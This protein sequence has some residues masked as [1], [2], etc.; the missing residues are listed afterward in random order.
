MAA[1]AAARA[2]RLLKCFVC[3]KTD[4]L[5]PCAR[6]K[7]VAHCSDAHKREHWAHGHKKECFP[8][9]GPEF[10]AAAASIVRTWRQQGS[11]IR[12][13]D[14][15]TRNASVDN[16]AF[17]SLEES[18]QHANDWT[19]DWDMN[20]SRAEEAL[21]RDDELRP[22]VWRAYVAARD[23]AAAPAQDN[24][25]PAVDGVKL[26]C[27]ADKQFGFISSSAARG[28]LCGTALVALNVSIKQ[29]QGGPVHAIAGVMN[30]LHHRASQGAHVAEG[31]V[32]Q[33]GDLRCMLVRPSA[34]DCAWLQAC[35][36]APESPAFVAASNAGQSR[37]LV[38]VRVADG[39]TKSDLQ[40]LAELV[41]DM[42]SG[43]EPSGLF[44]SAGAGAAR[45][46]E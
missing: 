25:A 13:M 14:R 24:W 42:A 3:D 44:G 12:F 5:T 45:R 20:I 40:R 1:D 10:D 19:V 4:A 33:S 9:S 23:A 6:C 34:P 26:K 21:V 30:L 11:F 39:E 15:N 27:M 31:Q 16:L 29:R 28:A 22:L 8:R 43:R 32:V 18:L 2:Q 38:L 36:L 41:H 46:F 37:V 35:V 7:S 17:V